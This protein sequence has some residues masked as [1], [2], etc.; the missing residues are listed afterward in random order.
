MAIF[1]PIV[2]AINDARKAAST[3]TQKY[4]S[5]YLSPIQQKIN[6]YLP[7]FAPQFRPPVIPKQPFEEVSKKVHN[8]LVQPVQQ[9]VQ[10][11]RQPIQFPQ[12]SSIGAEFGKKLQQFPDT[13]YVNPAIKG[14]KGLIDEIQGFTTS[15]PGNIIR[16]TGKAFEL[17]GTQRGRQEIKTGISQYP[18]QIKNRDIGGLLDN[19]A[20]VALFGATNVIPG[21]GIVPGIGKQTVK[22]ALKQGAKTS[23]INEIKSGFSAGRE[24]KE[25]V[26]IGRNVS[27]RTQLLDK[28]TPVFD[29]VKQAGKELPAEVNPYKKMR[30]FAGVG[31]QI[32]ASIERGLGPVFKKESQRLDDLSSLLVLERSLEL[33]KRGIPTR[34]GSRQVKTALQELVDKHGPEGIKTLRESAKQV[35]TYG[36]SLLSEL[37][38]AG[39][40]S[41]P[42]FNAIKKN[43]QFYVPFEIVEH[44]ADNLEKGSFAKPSFNVTTQNI[45]KTIKGS[46]KEL[47][48]PLEALVRR[49]SKV[50]TISQKN[51]AMQSLVNLRNVD[52]IFKDLIKPVKGDAVSKGMEK[53]SL[54]EN[55]KK[56]DYAVSE[57]VAA[58]VKNLDAQ[59]S[60]ILVDVLS[61]QA[62]LL[63]AGATGL[64]I[65]FIPANIVRDFSDAV[66][67][68]LTEKGVRQ[69]VKLLSSYPAAIASS[70]RKD[71]LYK[72]W[73]QAGGSQ[74]SLTSQLFSRTP[75]TVKKL[76]G[77]KEGLVKTILT[78]PKSLIEF[79]NR[80]G[81]E[82]TRVARFKAGL[83]AG[84]SAAEAAFKSRD[85]TID[86]AK[87]G[88]VIKLINQVIPYLNAGIQGS[89]R[90]FRLA[91]NNPGK[92]AVTLASLGGFPATMLYL[93]NKQFQDYKDIPQYEKDGNWI[94]LARDRTP[95]ERGNGD[96]VVGIKIPKGFLPGPV[97]NLTEE[98]L[99]FL[100]KNDPAS[101]ADISYRMFE[102]L[103]PV[104]FP[105]SGRFYSQ[106]L[107]P[108]IQA[109]VE[110]FTNTNLF[111][112]RD[113]VPQGL[114]DVEPSEQYNENT[115][116]FLVEIGKI[117]NVSPLKL[118]NIIGT[119]TGGVG[120]QLTELAS[121]NIKEAT[122]K[123]VTKRFVGVQSEERITAF[124]KEM[125][126]TKEVRNTANRLIKTK[127]GD[128]ET[129][130]YIRN[131]AK[132]IV[133]A[134][135]LNKVSKKLREIR[136][137]KRLVQQSSKS[138]NEKK[139]ILKKLNIVHDA[140][141]QVALE[142]SD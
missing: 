135:Q 126:K 70:L 11:A 45:I 90:I 97:A 19:P 15:L 124:Y 89:E 46:T 137:A 17:L 40:I 131:N 2:S 73:L 122:I 31:G 37:K 88:N 35:R 85:V 125:V 128:P 42:S 51:R 64:N 58:A 57:E 7:N 34:Y 27:T 1:D 134:K 56:V 3:I 113:I 25:A 6:N 8:Y 141:I 9:V 68:T 138:E 116:A 14:N 4:A 61:W 32:E 22:Q 119:T 50:I 74:S 65:G 94:V 87:N 48:D 59:S 142:V 75:Q 67:G 129:L 93:H 91:K 43:N 66:F 92:F 108:G 114:Q 104:G 120:K 136:D 98:F 13:T 60:N 28:F 71:D 69:T 133:K 41:S 62:K 111:T 52:E 106:V 112:G 30:L 55:G 54:L 24:A 38:D 29:L 82:S 16:E 23:V 20:T 53:I 76:A 139:K 72:K 79:A 102:Q 18:Q 33:E 44:I 78:S 99:R 100:D 96:P 109:G 107:P 110:T 81:E 105:G 123:P 132:D 26:S 47:G 117:L 121:G 21:G 39:I 5:Q 84:E 83:E 101:L 95:E 49:A 103:S 130:K 36:D 140:I 127:P 10:K 63:R 77:Q 115:P 12:G 118:Q 80:V 86:F